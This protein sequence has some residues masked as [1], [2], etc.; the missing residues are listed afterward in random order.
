MEK[1][2]AW[3]APLLGGCGGGLGGLAITGDPR[4]PF[5]PLQATLAGVALGVLAGLIVWVWDTLKRAVDTPPSAVIR[6][7]V[8]APSSRRKGILFILGGIGCLVAN[9]ILVVAGGEKFFHLIVGGS[10]FLA[11]GLAGVLLPQILTAGATGERV[12]WWGH[13][14]GGILA[15]AGLALGMYLWLAVY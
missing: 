12:S 11:I 14:A 1:W 13:L 10:F 6:R 2:P 9:H 5:P 4:F 8:T 7:A 15:V 3:S